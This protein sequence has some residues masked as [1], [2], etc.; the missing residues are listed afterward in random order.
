MQAIEEKSAITFSCD[1]IINH[2]RSKDSLPSSNYSVHHRNLSLNKKGNNRYMCHL[3]PH[4]FIYLL[5]T[6]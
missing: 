2:E 3:S 1:K 6:T 5:F 4:I